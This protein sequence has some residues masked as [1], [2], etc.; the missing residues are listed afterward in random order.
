MNSYAHEFAATGLYVNNKNITKSG[1]TS[2]VISALFS[3]LTYFFMSENSVSV[4]LKLLFIASVYFAY[5]VYLY[6]S[7]IQ[8]YYKEL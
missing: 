1:I 3:F 8:V 7:K 2:F 5:R 6:V 4:W